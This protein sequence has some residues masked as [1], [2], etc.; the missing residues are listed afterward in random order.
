LIKDIPD[1]ET[2]MNRLISEYHLTLT[3]LKKL[4][5]EEK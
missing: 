5:R 1:V 3:K 2:V 4:N